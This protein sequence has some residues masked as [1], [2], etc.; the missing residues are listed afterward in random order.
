[1]VAIVLWCDLLSMNIKKLI[2]TQKQFTDATPQ[3]IQEEISF[4][5]NTEVKKFDML[6]A[7]LRKYRDSRIFSGFVK[8]YRKICPSSN[9]YFGGA[10]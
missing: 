1:M 10:K 8:W 2:T 3:T 5:I 6:S 9:V 4:E 7:L